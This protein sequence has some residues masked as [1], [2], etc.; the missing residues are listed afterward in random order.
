ME[1]QKT[2]DNGK[3]TLENGPR[4][5][6]ELEGIQRFAMAVFG[7]FLRLWLSSLRFKL[8]PEVEAFLK[9]EQVPVV[10]ILWH[11]RLLLAPELYRRFLP[12]RKLAGLISAS[13]DGAWLAGFFE[14]LGIKPIRGSRHGRGVQAFREL[15]KASRDGYDIGITPDGSRGPIYEMKEGAATLALRGG[16]SILLLSYNY[17]RAWRLKSWDRFYIP[18]PF[19][20]VNVQVDDVG[21][22]KGFAGGDPKRAAELLR[23]RLMAITEDAEYFTAQGEAR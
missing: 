3:V 9:K 12:Q 2:V 18:L 20:R 21:P 5:P 4:S 19:S 13:G 11:N 23:E 6:R 15:M 10:A 8:S 14:Q 16:A 1:Q 7:F 22:S 17:T